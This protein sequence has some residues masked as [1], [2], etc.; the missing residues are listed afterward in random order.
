[1]LTQTE[2]HKKLYAGC[3]IVALLLFFTVLTVV[4]WKG[5]VSIAATPEEFAA[6]VR[7]FGW[8]GFFVMLGFQVLQVFIALIPG[9]VVEIAAGF[10][11]GALGG[12]I[13]CLLGV[14]VASSVVF[15]LVKKFGRPLVEIFVPGEK[16]DQLSFLRD[17]EKLKRIVFLIYFIPGTPKDLL[18]YFAGMTKMKLGEFLAISLVARIPSVVTSTVG[19]SFVS[20]GDYLHAGIVF[21]ATALVSLAGIL[22]YRRVIARQHED[23]RAQKDI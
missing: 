5:F 8:A 16:I 20:Q 6:Y 15:L 14:T 9:E 21:A 10:A 2:K 3:S 22:V 11:F 4:L 1:M 23:K 19:G 17:A 7:S 12:T 18:T 13:L